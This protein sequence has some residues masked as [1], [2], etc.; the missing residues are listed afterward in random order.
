V[1]T[2]LMLLPPMGV[3]VSPIGVIV[4]QSELNRIADLPGPTATGEVG[5]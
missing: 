5:D 4:V 1:L 3:F 2:L